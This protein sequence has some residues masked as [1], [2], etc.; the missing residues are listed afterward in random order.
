L[1]GLLNTESKVN[2][3][4]FRRDDK[5]VCLKNS[6]VSLADPRN[7]FGIDE[8]LLRDGQVYVANGQLA[9]VI[10]VEEKSLIATIEKSDVVIR[11]PRGKQTESDD[12]E[13][14][15]GNGCSFDLAYGLSCHKYQGSECPWVIVLADEYA[16]AKRIYSFEWWYTAWSRGRQQVFTIGRRSTV[17]AAIRRRVLPFRKTF[18][19][20]QIGL[21]TA[22]K[23]LLEMV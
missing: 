20:E 7:T 21:I 9:K 8:S 6:Y 18:L 4:V 15:G 13:D 1:Q 3:T 2:G 12:G 11:I 22:E 16:G 5:I 17:D 14:D 23:M 19:R 10:E